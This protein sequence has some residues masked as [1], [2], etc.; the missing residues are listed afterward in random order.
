MQNS[1]MANKL[2]DPWFGADKLQHAVGSC[3][4]VLV[5]YA[6]LLFPPALRRRLTSFRLRLALSM[7][8]AAAVGGMKEVGDGEAWW[9]FCP[10]MASWR[11]VLWDA[12]GVAV[13]GALVTLATAAFTRGRARE[14]MCRICPCGHSSKRPDAVVAV[15]LSVVGRPASGEEEPPC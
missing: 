15:S 2:A 6:V 9:W 4:I 11:D 5:V 10:C 7:L 3:G 14:R 1:T 13:G 12:V 8:A